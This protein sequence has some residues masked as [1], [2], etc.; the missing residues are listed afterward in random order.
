M[1]RVEKGVEEE[2]RLSLM[3]PQSSSNS[4]NPNSEADGDTGGSNLAKQ[5]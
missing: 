2:K 3:S 5:R 4:K 1:N